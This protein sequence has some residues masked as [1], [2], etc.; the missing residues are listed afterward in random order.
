MANLKAISGATA[1]EMAKLEAN[2]R[3]L[4]AS[5]MFTASQVGELSVN[6]AKLGF[7]AGDI[8]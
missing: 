3:K 8:L 1:P 6:Y 5:T 7:S 2:A 4:G